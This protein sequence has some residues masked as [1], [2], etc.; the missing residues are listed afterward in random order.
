MTVPVLSDAQ[1]MTARLFLTLP[2]SGLRVA[3]KKRT[4]KTYKGFPHGM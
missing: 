2:P 1:P 3:G 4:L